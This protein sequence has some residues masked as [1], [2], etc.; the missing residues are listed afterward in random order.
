[1]ETSGQEA[2]PAD[3]EQAEHFEVY[4][5]RDSLVR[6]GGVAPL[7]TGNGYVTLLRRFLLTI[8][9]LLLARISP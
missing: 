8:I 6:G 5:D 9:S 3:S 2:K 7:P 1:M 4:M